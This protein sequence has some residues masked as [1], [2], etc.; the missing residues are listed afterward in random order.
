MKK[1]TIQIQFD[2]EKLS[3]LQ[4]YLKQKNI[5]FDN[6][7]QDALNDL[8]KKYVP[9]SI[10]RYFALKN[11]EPLP[12]TKKLKGEQPGQNTDSAI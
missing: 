7:L 6:A 8:Y 2:E 5:S 4:I 1:A 11:N 12:A 10:R 3:T 9:V